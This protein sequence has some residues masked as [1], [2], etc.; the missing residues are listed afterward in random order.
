MNTDY[1][2]II[3]MEVHVELSTQTKMFC[4][5]PADHFE[6][7]ANSQTCPVCLGLPG[8]LPVP[9]KEAIKRTQ[10]I[11]LAMSCQLAPYSKFD[12]KNYF[13]PDLPKGYQIS[14]YDLP[15]AHH[16]KIILED[17]QEIAIERVHLE[18]DTAKNIHTPEGTLI[19]FN[20][21]GVPL[22]EIVTEPDL[23]SSVQTTIFL[24]KLVQI[25]K[26]LNVGS[27][28][29]EKGTLRLEANI[30]VRKKGER[31]LPDYKVEIKNVN[32]FRY[33]EKAID[34][35]IERQTKL[36]EEGKTPI[37][38][39][40][41][42]DENKGVTVSQRTKEGAN[43]YRYFPEPDIPPLRFTPEWFAEIRSALPLLPQQ[44]KDMLMTKYQLNESSATLIS[45]NP[46][47]FQKILEI[48]NLKNKDLSF[49]TIANA[50]INKKIDSSL[51]AQ[52]IV[53][54]LSR[55]KEIIETAEL[56]K[57]VRTVLDKN[58]DAVTSYQKGKSQVVGFL[59]GIIARTLSQPIDPTQVRE[60]LEKELSS[61]AKKNF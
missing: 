30:S 4:S 36:L 28:D 49:Q 17:G 22:V 38:E 41:G 44:I 12:R 57:I 24:K 40:R 5:C 54:Q 21:S 27:C 23:T 50:L 15:F 16:G 53:E 60:V 52:T 58:P 61:Y 37:Q 35:E 26:S 19:N 45:Q 20:R 2:P 9:N 1:E 6:K 51:S 11:G 48:E 3:G 39:T 25:I 33:I 18:E 47:L 29:M 8:A 7:E 56:Q 14:Q 59:I 32:S 13:Y 34:F 42:F 31:N 43:D 46:I 10:L 55:P